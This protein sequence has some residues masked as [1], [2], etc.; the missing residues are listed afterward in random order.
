MQRDGDIVHTDGTSSIY[1]I[2]AATANY[3]I[4]IK[5][6]NHL[7][8]MTTNT[9]ALSATSTM[10]DFTDANN[11]ITYGTDA[12]TAFGLPSGVVAMWTGDV[13][14]DGRLNY[15]GALSD[16]PSIR[17]QVFND[18]DNSVFGGPPT[19]TYVFLQQLPEGAND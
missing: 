16:V 10:V 2:N 11:Q 17:S 12:Q 15:S 19:S 4:V 1:F 5:H 8:I 3:Y 18:P 6:R 14:G 13:N 9:V 7:G